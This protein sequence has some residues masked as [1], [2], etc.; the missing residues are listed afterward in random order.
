MNEATTIQLLRT[1][2]HSCSYLKD[3]IATTEFVAP[4]ENI[5]LQG[6]QAINDAGFRRSG[7]HFYRPR[8]ENC[9]ECKPLRVL[10]KEFSPSKSQKRILKKNAAL[11]LSIQAGPDAASYFDLYERYI[12]RRHQDGDMYPPDSTQFENF[13]CSAPEW[14]RF[15]EFRTDKLIMVAVC[16]FLPNGL[17]AIYSFFDPDESDRSLGSYAILAEIDIARRLGLPYLYLGYWIKESHKMNYKNRFRPCE[18]LEK[19]NWRT[20]PF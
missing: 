17:S 5:S 7:A 3:A 11:K 1:E 18:L 13:I 10:T 19:G 9:D 8:C 16:D 15:I 2:S 12:L 4:E 6:Y 20:M 14:A